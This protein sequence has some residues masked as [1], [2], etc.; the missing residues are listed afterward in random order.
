M[1]RRPKNRRFEAR[2]CQRWE[3]SFGA[4]GPWT[5]GLVK[6]STPK[7]AD[8]LVPWC[9]CG[10]GL[11]RKRLVVFFFWWCAAAS[12]FVPRMLWF[13]VFV[14]FT[15]AY[16]L[17]AMLHSNYFFCLS[18]GWWNGRANGWPM[19]PNHILRFYV[20]NLLRQGLDVVSILKKSS[21]SFVFRGILSLFVGSPKRPVKHRAVRGGD[22]RD[23]STK[24]ALDEEGSSIALIL[25]LG[26]HHLDLMC[27]ER[28]E[29]KELL[30][31]ELSFDIMMD[32]F[33][34]FNF[35]GGG[36][37]GLKVIKIDILHVPIRRS[38]D[39]IVFKHTNAEDRLIVWFI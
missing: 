10:M 23:R 35:F 17:Y 27:L 25:D 19:D 21:T 13:S 12:L 29:M 2:K 39:A 37:K 28:G 20:T 16:M 38:N 24:K 30:L 18:M 6:G 36:K 7:M 32:L 14:Q 31:V 26:A 11:S 15:P 34:L 22:Q 3:T 4:M 5:L 9:R 1:Y 33:F 8:R